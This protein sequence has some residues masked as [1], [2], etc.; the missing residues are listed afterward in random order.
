[1]T[2]NTV[3]PTVQNVAQAPSV[4]ES[5]VASGAQGSNQPPQPPEKRPD[6]NERERGEQLRMLM[7]A[8]TANAGGTSDLET[9][10]QR[11]L[12]EAK[13][14]LEAGNYS[15][16][17]FDYFSTA[18]R[19]TTATALTAFLNGYLD[20]MSGLA[21]AEVLSRDPSIGAGNLIAAIRGNMETL[22]RRLPP[23]LAQMWQTRLAE[24]T[25]EQ[26]VK[27][28]ELNANG[29]SRD[30]GLGGG[31]YTALQVMSGKLLVAAFD[32]LGD[33]PTFEQVKEQVLADIRAK[34]ESGTF[35][36]LTADLQTAAFEQL[37]QEGAVALIDIDVDG[38]LSNILMQMQG[39]NVP[40]ANAQKELVR[41]VN[42]LAS[43][44]AGENR[45]PAVVRNRALARI[46]A[47][48]LPEIQ[49]QAE[50]PEEAETASQTKSNPTTESEVGSGEASETETSPMGRQLLASRLQ[51]VQSLKQAYA[52]A[53]A[54][55][56]DADPTIR[57]RILGGMRADHSKTLSKQDA[58][59]TKMMPSFQSLV[60]PLPVPE[61]IRAE[62]ANGGSGSSENTEELTEE[63]LAAREGARS[64]G[65]QGAKASERIAKPR[66]ERELK[67]EQAEDEERAETEAEAAKRIR[68]EQEELA[69]ALAA[70]QAEITRE[71]G[72]F[73]EFTDS[74]FSF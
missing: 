15:Q 17:D 23:V 16:A 70:A 64:A 28:L 55:L 39:E 36:A 42:A 21:A 40:A 22:A 66:S 59:H 57:E 62:H 46:Q 1:M 35:S 72:S 61:H 26:L 44:E 29:G 5:Q 27:L 10:K 30:R 34:R 69:K 6:L 31:N 3:Q 18:I 14:Q 47:G 52:E 7:A 60:A 71:V 65:Y 4:K 12:Q 50:I 67:E 8:G 32:K 58:L 11:A 45:I 37:T 54:Q 63:Q 56:A 68:E 9:V 19:S 43:E 25:P 38:L 2:E 53:V 73:S 13:A 74:N 48:D 24:T 51:L 41:R 33:R 49:Q 20:Q